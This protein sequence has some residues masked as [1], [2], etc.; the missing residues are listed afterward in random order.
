[1]F[2]ID[3]S[4]LYSLAVHLS[5]NNL[6]IPEDF[7]YIRG[8]AVDA[9]VS[10]IVENQDPAFP[11]AG[12]SAG[13]LN[14]DLLLYYSSDDARLGV[15]SATRVDAGLTVD[16]VQ[17]ERGLGVSEEM[18]FTGTHDEEL[19]REQCPL[20][21]FLCVEILPSAEA[22]PSYVLFNSLNHMNCIDIRSQ[23]TLCDGETLL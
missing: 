22:N 9:D 7:R 4:V 15:E 11:V 23:H 14:Y 17:L 2:Y 8:Y 16:S 21:E 10:I 3:I 19:S 20:I 13:R 12:V 18:E 5:V 1:M 6:S